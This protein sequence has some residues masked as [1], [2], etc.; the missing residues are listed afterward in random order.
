[1]YSLSEVSEKTGLPLRPLEDAARA[2]KFRHR[3]MFGRRWMTQAQ[4]DAYVA[5]MEVGP[6][7]EPELLS[8]EDDNEAMKR[9]LRERAERLSRR[10]SRG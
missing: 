3:R 10:R 6:E 1:M 2:N 4:I 9:R 8:S 5:S 7:P